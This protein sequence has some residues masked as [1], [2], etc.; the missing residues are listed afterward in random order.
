VFDFQ[1]TPDSARVVYV[2]TEPGSQVLQLYSVLIDA[3]GPPTL[4]HAPLGAA[5]D[6]YTFLISPTSS[7]VVYVADQDVDAVRE[8][9]SVPVDGGAAP[10]KLNSPL[11]PG[12]DVEPGLGEL[13]T[14]GV[15]PSGEY[16]V[17]VADQDT[18]GLR[19]LYSVPIDASAPP[20]KLSPTPAPFSVPNTPHTFEFTSD[21][22]HLV[23]IA[24]APGASFSELFAAPLDGGHP[25]TKINGSVAA[26]ITKFAIAPNNLEIL[27]VGEQTAG[28]EELF[29]TSLDVSFPPTKI[30]DTI[31]G[32]EPDLF[33][34]FVPDSR[35]VLYLTEQDTEDVYEL[36]STKLRGSPR[37]GGRPTTI[38]EVEY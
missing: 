25:A 29:Q 2:S 3:S 19:E 18:D 28:V 1:I 36:Y 38:V 31:V 13:V 8:I 22:Q 27:Y 24:R 11:V 7:H 9:Y 17:Y 21:S 14:Y 26:A 34:S 12:G 23:F 10:T 6:V 5:Q 20:V 32:N 15:S 37:R 30:S 35:R 16:V 4:L 33:F